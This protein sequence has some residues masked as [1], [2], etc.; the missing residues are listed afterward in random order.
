MEVTYV[1]QEHLKGCVIACCAMITGQTYDQVAAH[2]RGNRDEDG[3]QL[4]HALRYITDHG[5]A[6]QQVTAHG[7]NDLRDSNR[8]MLRPFADAHLVNV[9]PCVNS[10]IGHALVMDG[11]GRLH[12]PEVPGEVDPMRFYFVNMVVGVYDERPRIEK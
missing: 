4:Q 7:Y 9:L 8:R 5:F 3:V 12:D 6:A 1:K 10:D 2:F 11:S